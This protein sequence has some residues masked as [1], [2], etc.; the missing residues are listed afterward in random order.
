MTV[1][2]EAK[3]LVQQESGARFEGNAAPP[4]K[5]AKKKPT[6]GNPE[7]HD[8]SGVVEKLLQDEAH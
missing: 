8:W 5:S 2:G 4:K 7:D 3:G 1:F 6:L